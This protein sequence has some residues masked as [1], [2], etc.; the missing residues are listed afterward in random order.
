[1]P[2]RKLLVFDW[3]GTL[4][5]SVDRIVATLQHAARAAGVAAP[6]PARAKSVI[7]LGLSEAMMALFPNESVSVHHSLAAFYKK[8]FSDVGGHTMQ[9]FPG[10]RDM[11]Q[12]AK[13]RGHMLAIAT[14]KGR[15]GLDQMLA[16][17]Q[18]GEFF[19]ATRCADETASKPNPKML[20]ELMN[21]LNVDAS[22]TV[23]IGDS[24][25]D[26]DMAVQANVHRIAVTYG[27]Q[28]R[29]NMIPYQPLAILDNIRQLTDWLEI[30]EMEAR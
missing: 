16:Q 21:E 9:L 2:S 11:L 1:M 6:D 7:G 22:E 30:S 15:R 13:A 8:I 10:A 29:L 5:D 3:D 18:L 19:D 27:V 12:A 20:F 25:H 4:Y 17:E 28:T 14:G 26:M 23:M 24:L